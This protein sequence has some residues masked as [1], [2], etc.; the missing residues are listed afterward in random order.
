MPTAPAL[1]ELL[2]ATTAADVFLLVNVML[3]A[4]AAVGSANIA[5]IATMTI[6]S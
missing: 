3:A 4:S 1:F 5:Q 2:L 6:V